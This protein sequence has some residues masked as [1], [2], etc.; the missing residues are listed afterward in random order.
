MKSNLMRIYY[1]VASKEAKELFVSRQ[2]ILRRSS[3]DCWNE[4]RSLGMAAS[5]DTIETPLN[6]SVI[7]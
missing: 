6:D 5:Y 3:Q 2:V 4:M 7:E 1:F